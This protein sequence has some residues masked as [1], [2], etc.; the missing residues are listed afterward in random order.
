MLEP[1]LWLAREP[2]HSVQCTFAVPCV[3]PV[4]LRQKKPYLVPSA[5]LLTTVLQEGTKRVPSSWSA[6][7]P[8]I[9]SNPSA[10][11][12]LYVTDERPH[13]TGSW[14]RNNFKKSLTIARELPEQKIN[15]DMFRHRVMILD[16][17]YIC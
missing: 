12:I 6:Q 3:N 7:R 5:F 17:S 13:G 14:L 8:E 15:G 16:I 9:R 2:S 11:P 1:R 10:Q 4:V